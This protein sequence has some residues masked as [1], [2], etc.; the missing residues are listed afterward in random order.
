MAQILALA[1]ILI[2]LIVLT[3]WIFEIA[4]LKTVFPGYV[5]M[6][7]NTAVNFL[8]CGSA[9]LIAAQRVQTPLKKGMGAFL[10]ICVL[11]ISGITLMEYLTHIPLGIDE[12]LFRDVNITYGTSNPGRMAPNTALTFLLMACALIALPRGTRGVRLA[13]LLVMICFFNVLLPTVGYFFHAQVFITVFSK[14][15]LAVHTI[16]GI[17]FLIL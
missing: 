10:G 15:T 4:A 16:I 3:G 1:A 13:Q 6:K 9:L 12:L 14:T 5:S 17:Y 11:L 8:F 7:V 2:A